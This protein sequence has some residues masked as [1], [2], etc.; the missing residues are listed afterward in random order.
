MPSGIGLYERFYL[1]LHT[2]LVILIALLI[3]ILRTVGPYGVYQMSGVDVISQGICTWFWASNGD[4]S[5][6]LIGKQSF[7]DGSG[8]TTQL[9]ALSWHDIANCWG[10]KTP[11]TFNDITKDL[12]HHHQSRHATHSPNLTILPTPQSTSPRQQYTQKQW[13]GVKWPVV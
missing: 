12:G 9:F 13:F 2:S 4:V 10:V 3:Y 1:L 7:K 5:D 6:S 8:V 11:T